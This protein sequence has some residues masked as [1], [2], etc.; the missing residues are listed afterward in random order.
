[1]NKYTARFQ[2]TG[3]VY[4]VGEVQKFDSGFSKREIVI[5]TNET[6]LSPVPLSFLKDDCVKA[7]GINIGDEVSVEGFVNGREWKSGDGRVKCFSDL[8]IRSITVTN[9]A[10]AP[11][12][13]DGET[14]KAFCKVKGIDD[15]R[16]LEACT[17]H[18]TKVNRKFTA[19][20]WKAV[21][22]ALCPKTE[23]AP[24]TTAP[25]AGDSDDLPF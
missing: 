6:R 1:M 21:A 18:K 23:K 3:A 12:V 7:D 4:K 25:E 22:D 14:L 15:E 9:R 20:D 2:I 24:E 5:N 10:V 13:T 8:V 16:M 17:A 11:E 19:E